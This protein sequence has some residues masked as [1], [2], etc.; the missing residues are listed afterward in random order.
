[1]K[2]R[3]NISGVLEV[4]HDGTHFCANDY[5][6][7]VLKEQIGLLFGLGLDSFEGTDIQADWR[8][9]WVD[10][11]SDANTELPKVELEIKS[12]SRVEERPPG[13]TL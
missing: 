7:G 10:G 12:V 4:E 9:C 3:F 6:L 13:T 2:T 8:D 1:M 11:G 5:Q